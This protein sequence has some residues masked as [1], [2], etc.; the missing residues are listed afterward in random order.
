MQSK[1]CP[2]LSTLSHGLPQPT[3]I[4]VFKKKN[5]QKKRQGGFLEVE[6]WGGP[7]VQSQ[8]ESSLSVAHFGVSIR[9][10]EILMVGV[11]LNGRRSFHW[12]E[13]KNKT[14]GRSVK[15]PTRLCTIIPKAQQLSLPYQSRLGRVN[16]LFA[17]NRRQRPSLPT[18]FCGIQTTNLLGINLMNRRYRDLEFAFVWTGARSDDSAERLVLFNNMFHVYAAARRPQ[19]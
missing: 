8:E 14:K 19:V 1:E 12:K 16:R 15:T 6:W 10:F 11:G 9:G 4:F 7:R 17:S 5:K 18:C 2:V 13:N 3:M